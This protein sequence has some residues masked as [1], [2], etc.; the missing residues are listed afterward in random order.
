MRFARWTFRVAGVYGLIV[1]TSQLF[2]EERLG[3]DYPPPVTHPEFFYG[4][5][6]VALAW[7]VL[8]LVVGSDPPRFLPVMLPAVLAKLSF[9]L[10]V[11]ILYLMSRVS[12]VIVCLTAMDAV[13]A[14]LFALAWFS[15]PR[16]N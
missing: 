5:A 14:V 13:W 3:R 8:F 15:T 1:L 9:A 16:G 11:L 2:L 7:Q 10:A 6:G 4:F 12:G